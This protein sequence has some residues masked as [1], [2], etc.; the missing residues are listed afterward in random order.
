MRYNYLETLDHMEY[1]PETTL[2]KMVT[3]IEMN[4]I[5]KNK[6]VEVYF[7]LHKKCWSVRQSGRPVIHTDFKKGF[8]RAETVSFEDFINN[9]GWTNSKTN[10]KMR[11]EGKDYIVKDGDILNFRFNT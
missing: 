10:G 3:I 4:G 2:E 5:D 7:N 11:L 9:Q 1:I 6:K 8:I